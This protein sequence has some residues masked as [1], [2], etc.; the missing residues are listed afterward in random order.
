[1][2][3]DS[4]TMSTDHNHFDRPKKEPEDW[5]KADIKAALEK[6]GWTLR[7]LSKAHGYSV[8]AGAVTFTQPWRNM[9]RIIA[10]AIGR[11]PE[12]IWPSRYRNRAA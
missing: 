6:A 4:P 5:H 1:M 9:E 12:E 10:R 2:N 8:N 3:L 7:K 11:E